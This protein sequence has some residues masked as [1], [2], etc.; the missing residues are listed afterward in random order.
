MEMEKLSKTVSNAGRLS[1]RYKIFD[2]YI[3]RCKL[4]NK[5]YH[6]IFAF[7][8]LVACAYPAIMYCFTKELVF[9]FSCYVPFMDPFTKTGY[10]VT[11]VLHLLALFSVYNATVGIDSLFIFAVVQCAVGVD[12]FQVQIE[13]FNE[14]LTTNEDRVEDWKFYGKVKK[15]LNLIIKSHQAISNAISRVGDIF[16]WAIA[17]QVGLSVVSLAISLFMTMKVIIWM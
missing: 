12:M 8:S 3:N 5:S 4:I 10:T 15:H 1:R 11:M 7:G 2:Q 16:Y 9:P 14:L 17:V 13:E 6:V